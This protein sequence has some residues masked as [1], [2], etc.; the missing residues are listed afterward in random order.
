MIPG[1]GY[2]V[3]GIGKE[4]FLCLISAVLLVFSFPNFNLWIF[5]WVSF[6]PL[7]FA[8]ENKSRTKAF[9]LF[10]LAGLIFW[11][12]TIYWL[13]HVTLPGM[14]ILALY[15]AVYF[16]IF[17]FIISYPLPLTPY[18]LLF[19]P[20]LWVV[21][22]YLRGYLFTG[23]PWALLAYSQYRN[24]PIIQIADLTGCWGVS[25]LIMMVNVAIYSV[26][27]SRFSVL[28]RKSRLLLPLAC[29]LLSLIYGYYR[30]YRAPDIEHWTPIK[31]S[32]IQPNIPQ[33]LKWDTRARDFILQRYLSLTG[34]A[35]KDRP[36]LIIW[37]EAALPATP[38][39]IP[40]YYQMVR[41]SVTRIKAPL[42][43]GAVTRRQELYYNSA[44]LL[45]PAGQ[46][47]AAY[48]KLHLVPF[49]EYIP[50][51][52]W[53]GFLEKAVPIADF[54]PGSQYAIFSYPLPLTPYPYKFAV[55]ICFEDLFPELSRQFV[56]RGVD[57]LVNITN[58]AWFGYSS[59][60]YQHLQASV[61][62]AVENR[63]A[64]V[65]AAN[66]GISGFITASGK[67]ISLVGDCGGRNI[68]TAGYKTAEINLKRRNLS[69]YSRYGD[70]FLGGCLLLVLYAI[71]PL[72]NPLRKSP[73]PKD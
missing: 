22:E 9:L 3:S 28:G 2:R 27:G 56:K 65:R 25:F 71:I 47:L 53:L 12:G 54:T 19:I 20:C 73:R 31:I 70:L 55:L 23:F 46:L 15:L 69:F 35:A 52:K 7:F 14:I 29:I 38:E 4:I 51:R 26:C 21:L 44:L 6:V 18:P 57:F 45:S 61:F 17:G 60:P 59:A 8:A 43:L 68:F 39:E 64:L 67:V 62:R 10:Y 13:I 30:I 32:V 66:T 5:A 48:H 37:P 58:D 50:L 42:L 33:H 72:F 63:V 40:D 36:D 16:G 24:L 11:L 49:G 41:D 34:Q 1:I